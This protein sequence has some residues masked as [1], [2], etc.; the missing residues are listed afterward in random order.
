MITDNHYDRMILDKI[1]SAQLS[2]GDT[3]A[4]SY[5]MHDFI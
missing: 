1:Q 3:P 2:Y 5:L 4:T